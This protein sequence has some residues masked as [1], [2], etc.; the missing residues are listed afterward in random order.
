MTARAKRER[1]SFA[2]PRVFLPFCLVALI[3]G[4]TWLV[5][6]DQISTVPPSW[7]IAYR[8]MIA[9]AAMLVLLAIRREKLRVT[10]AGLPIVAIVGVTQ[11]VMNFQ[12][13]YRAEMTL[14]SGIVAL[15]FALILIPNSIL[16]WIVLGDRVSKGFV[17]GSAIALV[18]VG[19]LLVH[20][21]D[22]A[23]TRE[24][25]M[26][27][28]FMAVLATFSA[29]VANIT[30]ATERAHAQPFLPMLTVS[31]LLGMAINVVLALVLDGPPM[32]DPRP[33]YGLGL[34]YLGV[35]GSVVT[36]SLYFTLIRNMGAGRAAYVGVATPILAMLLSTLFE[37]YDWTALTI[38]GSLLSLVGL[39]LALKARS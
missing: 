35:A 21:Y 15:F 31:M 27:G 5:I 19:L 13:V 14:T 7:T 1:M 22:K 23:G 11:F 12:F 18:G 38:G 8:F 17:A 6:K 24:G 20:E 16:A 10:K 29:S 2:D 4:S 26:M 25:V 39:V 34:L 32:W 9:S 30:Q 37:G 36:F 3:W 28:V 33:Q